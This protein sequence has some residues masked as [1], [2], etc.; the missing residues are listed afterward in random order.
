M[1]YK[2]FK[3]KNMPKT[4]S[5]AITNAAVHA[6][7]D[8]YPSALR[9][10]LL[11]LRQLVLDTA[12][13]T[14]GVGALEETLKWGELAYVT[15]SKSGST[16]RIDRKKNADRYAMYF[17]CNTTLVDTFRSLFPGTFTFE[18]NR[19]LVFEVK[20]K[21]PREELAFCIGMALTYHRSKTTPP[22]SSQ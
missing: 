11:A 18:G 13:Q 20:D 15:L 19:A 10:K 14:E 16:V 12:A 7:F 9:S 2:P 3:L 17:N 21:L 4:P 1:D 5:P 6:V 22:N 8:S